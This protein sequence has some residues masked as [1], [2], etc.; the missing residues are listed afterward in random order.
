M[1]A[2]PLQSQMLA[3]IA[4]PSK[5]ARSTCSLYGRPGSNT[6]CDTACHSD[7]WGSQCSKAP[8]L[9]IPVNN[10]CASGFEHRACQAS[11][12]GKAGVALF[13]KFGL[14]RL[15]RQEG[16]SNCKR[17]SNG[18][19]KQGPCSG[20]G[21]STSSGGNPISS[22]KQHSAAHQAR[23][24]A[25]DQIVRRPQGRDVQDVSEP[26]V[27]PKHGHLVSIAGQQGRC[28]H[29]E[30]DSRMK[31]AATAGQATGSHKASSSTADRR[32]ALMKAIVRTTPTR[33]PSMPL[34]ADQ[35]SGSSAG[36]THNSQPQCEGRDTMHM[37]SF[38]ALDAMSAQIKQPPRGQSHIT[39]GPVLPTCGLEPRLKSDRENPSIAES[40]KA[41]PAYVS[42][43]RQVAPHT[44]PG[45]KDAAG[46]SLGSAG[47]RV[48]RRS[49][50]SQPDFC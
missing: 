46:A 32:K 2:P 40:C 19:L 35:P 30:A 23:D 18:T 37:Q 6:A 11:Q 47:T 31:Q 14:G 43:M 49:L 38:S 1:Q 20:R 5:P 28:Q 15:P 16:P 22:I 27:L 8:L 7:D 25:H 48:V 34:E 26:V 42:A 10:N 17:D 3:D 29:A 21:A 12:S 9:E 13:G 44:Q 36:K 33:A 50:L 41:V 45:T 4:I 24:L 39:G